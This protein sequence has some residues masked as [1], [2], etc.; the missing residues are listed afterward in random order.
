[1][2]DDRIPGVGRSEVYTFQCPRPRCSS[3]ESAIGSAPICRIHGIEMVRVGES[4]PSQSES[5]D[6]SIAERRLWVESR[7][8]AKAADGDI[9]K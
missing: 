2:V 7:R 6:L 9:P 8:A 1:M 3:R 5:T 4:S